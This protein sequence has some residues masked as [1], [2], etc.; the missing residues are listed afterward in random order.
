MLPRTWESGYL[1]LKL[2]CMWYQVLHH[3]WP[4]LYNGLNNRSYRMRL[5]WGLS[6]IIKLLRIIFGYYWYWSGQGH[7]ADHEFVLWGVTDRQLWCFSISLRREK[8]WPLGYRSGTLK[9]WDRESK[10][11]SSSVWG[12]LHRPKKAKERVL[13]SPNS[14]PMFHNGY[15]TRD[16]SALQ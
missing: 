15:D 13:Q 10:S 12:Y 7:F 5:L 16:P 2:R 11:S 9:I 14:S 6:E 1:G 3:S 4:H 8:A